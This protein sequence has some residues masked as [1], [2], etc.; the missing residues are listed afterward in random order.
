[1]HSHAAVKVHSVDANCWVVFNSQI[2]VFAD[3]KSEIACF[4]KVL[5]LQLVFLDLESTLENFFGFGSSH[6]DMNCNFLVA[7]DPKGTDSVAGLAFRAKTMLEV[8]WKKL[9]MKKGHTVYGCLTTKLFEHFGRTSK[10]ITG[11]AD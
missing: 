11:F 9:G 7:A 5:L 1:M 8:F 4:R 2:D 10:S 6:G 3:A